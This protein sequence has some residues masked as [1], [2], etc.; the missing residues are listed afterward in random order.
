[1]KRNRR[2]RALRARFAEKQSETTRRSEIVSSGQSVFAPITA[3]G[4]QRS[5]RRGQGFKSPHLHK[6][7]VLAQQGLLVVSGWLAYSSNP[8][9][10]LVD[11]AWSPL[12][13]GRHWA[14]RG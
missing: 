10:V 11:P 1:M 13:L 6:S 8:G 5:Q 7:G 4:A 9:S 14:E 12:I 3:M 2:P